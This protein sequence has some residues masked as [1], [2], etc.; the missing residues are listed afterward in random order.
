MQRFWASA[1]SNNFVDMP[2]YVRN[3]ITRAQ[4]APL[5]DVFYSYVQKIEGAHKGEECPQ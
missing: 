1:N 3:G 2:L 4:P 5:N